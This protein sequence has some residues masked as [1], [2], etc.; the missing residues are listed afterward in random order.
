M[1]N[2]TRPAIKKLAIL[3]GAAMRR[4][5]ACVQKRM[6]MLRMKCLL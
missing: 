2:V 1:C 3:E 6:E 4:E 5:S